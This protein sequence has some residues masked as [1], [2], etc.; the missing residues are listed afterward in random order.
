MEKGI[1]AKDLLKKQ[2]KENRDARKKI[3]KEYLSDLRD[4]P[5]NKRSLWLNFIA[6]LFQFGVYLQLL[7][8]W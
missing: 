3:Q 2:K 6:F 7:L 4:N 8:I 5:A 1:E